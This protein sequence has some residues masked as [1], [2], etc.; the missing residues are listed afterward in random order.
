MNK[1]QLFTAISLLTLSGTVSAADAS[2][3]KQ[4]ASNPF[5]RCDA[6]KGSKLDQADCACDVALSDGS[7]KTIQLFINKYAKEVSST[8]C[9]A[10]ALTLVV[11]EPP[12]RGGNSY[13]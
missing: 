13:N 7:A 1:K 4:V 10:L 11:K 12:S 5:Q 3:S 8:A 2:P 6:V 9:G